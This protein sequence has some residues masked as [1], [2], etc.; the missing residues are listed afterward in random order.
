VLLKERGSDEVLKLIGT[1]R[2]TKPFGRDR[3]GR[4]DKNYILKI[5]KI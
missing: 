3:I 1:A 2:D 5:L 4:V